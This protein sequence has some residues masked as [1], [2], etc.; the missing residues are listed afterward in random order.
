MALG[1][2][3]GKSPETN[4]DTGLS[5]AVETKESMVLIP[6]GWFWMGSP[7]EQGHLNERPL[8]RVWLDAY[9]LDALEV[10]FDQYD[11]FAQTTGRTK[12]NDE[13]WGRGE[14]PVIHINW[15][16]AEAY[17]QWA[18][19]RLPTEAEWEK[20]AWGNKPMREIPILQGTGTAYFWVKESKP[21][22]L[23][24]WY[25]GNSNQTTHPVGEKQPNPYGLYDILGNVWEWCSDWYEGDYSS[26]HQERNPKG[27]DSGE[28]KVLRGGAWDGE[29]VIQRPSYRI[30]FAPIEQSSN[31]GCRCAKTP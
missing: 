20:A 1:C 26:S 27:P 9:Q 13:S 23:F 19:K 25:M 11:K 5:K 28:W 10:T 29:P 3:K 15:K 12:P 17:C 14:R 30:G 6:A 22:D 16:E 8:H 18:G 7:E 21:L 2:G 31:I 24:A 4:G